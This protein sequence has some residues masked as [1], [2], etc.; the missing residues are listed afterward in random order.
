MLTALT[1]LLAA[2]SASLA[3]VNELLDPAVGD[4]V[5]VA[6]TPDTDQGADS[7]E[8]SQ[9]VSGEPMVD[10][11]SLFELGR[12]GAPRR[13]SLPTRRRLLGQRPEPVR[14]PA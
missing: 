10:P 11:G 7:I 5:P 4:V 1:K 6:L 12:R 8:E 2:P 14:P 13:R 9:V 3:R